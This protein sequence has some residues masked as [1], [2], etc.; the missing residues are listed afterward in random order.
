MAEDTYIYV[1]LL[2]QGSQVGIYVPKGWPL[3]R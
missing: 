1:Y 3:C 2:R